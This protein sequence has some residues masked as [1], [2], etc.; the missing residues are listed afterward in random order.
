MFTEIRLYLKLRPDLNRLKELSHMKLS[1]NFFGQVLLIILHM[2]NVLANFVPAADK[3]YIAAG[4][5]LVQLIIS[6][7]A[8]FRNPDGSSATAPYGLTDAQLDEYKRLFAG[9]AKMILLFAL[10]A[11]FGARV[12]AQ[13]VPVAFADDAFVS[14]GAV[15]N[16]SS[17]YH[18]APFAAY[19]QLV[20][21]PTS[22]VPTILF[23]RYE[24]Y[25][26][27]AGKP[28]YGMLATG[29]FIAWHSARWFLFG[30]IGLGGAGS[31]TA[32]SS[33]F[34]VGGGGGAIL[35]NVAT[36]HWSIEVEPKAERIP[37][38]QNPAGAGSNFN[39]AFLVAITRSFKKPQ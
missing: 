18:P 1:G 13:P 10:V 21:S 6:V 38:L 31:S 39:G 34:N 35:G 4:L 28:A 26:D 27:S 30:D 33:A 23:V 32:I 3:F 8:H 29:K 25:I 14:A 9:T 11:G 22:A 15:T 17:P 16:L 37:A 7:L 5:G 12:Y 20:N 24:G 36:S 2:G 19:G